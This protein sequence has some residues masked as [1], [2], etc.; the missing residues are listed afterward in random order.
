MGDAHAVCNALHAQVVALLGKFLA[1][2]QGV[3]QAVGA[4]VFPVA[5]DWAH[6]APPFLRGVRPFL[7]A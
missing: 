6:A 4:Q 7:K 3:H 2:A 1:Q 5:A